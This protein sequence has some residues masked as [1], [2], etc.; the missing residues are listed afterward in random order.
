MGEQQDNPEGQDPE[1]AEPYRPEDFV[2]LQYVP[3]TELQWRWARLKVV[4]ALTAVVVV[5]GMCARIMGYE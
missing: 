1:H 2:Q 3:P 5:V 4:G